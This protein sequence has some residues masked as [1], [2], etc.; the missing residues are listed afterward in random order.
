MRYFDAH[1]HFQDERLSACRDQVAA[2]LPAIGLVRAVV[3]GSGEEDW[4]AVAALARQHAWVVPS[5]G[6]HPWYVKEQTPSWRDTLLRYLAEFPAAGVGEIGLDRWIENPDVD[7]QTCLFRDQLEIA[8]AQNR[9][10]SIHCLRAFG[11]MDEVLRSVARPE[12]GFLLHSYGGPVE[13]IPGFVRLG[14]YFSVSP[15]FLHERKAR[16]WESFRQ[17]PLD[18]LLVETDAPDMWPPDAVNPHP[19]ST[20][21]GKPINHPANIEMMYEALAKHRELGVAELSQ[22]VEANFAELFGVA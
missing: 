8:H 17:V 12:R 14:A 13:M 22:Q 21:D 19:L 1:N 18:R 11:Q 5:F 6:V 15:Y 4:E 7:L 9:A 10:A 3:A 20:T 2:Q 16:Q